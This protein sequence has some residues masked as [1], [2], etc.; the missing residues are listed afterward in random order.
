MK[1]QSKITTENTLKLLFMEFSLVIFH[2]VFIK[3][4]YENA[5]KIKF[6]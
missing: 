3:I 2:W 6:H 4:S 1:T 5:M